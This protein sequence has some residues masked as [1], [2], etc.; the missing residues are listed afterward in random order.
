MKMGEV[1]LRENIKLLTYGTLVRIQLYRNQ[2]GMDVLTHALSA[3]VRW[4]PLR[5]MARE[6]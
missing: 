4:V 2:R 3:L 5:Q 1:C 6:A